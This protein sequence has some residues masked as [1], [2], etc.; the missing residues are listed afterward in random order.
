M[1]NLITDVHTTDATVPDV[2]A[3]AP[4]QHKLTEHGVKPTEHNLDSGYP[5]AGLITKAMKQGVHMVTPVL[6]DRSAQ[7]KA[8][9]GFDKTGFTINW[10]TRQVCSRRPDQLPL[11]PRQAAWQGCHRDHLQRP[12]LP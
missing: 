9:A 3:T 12:D 7:A 10:K 1:P 6:L 2:Q 5:S 8:D 4:I 11:E